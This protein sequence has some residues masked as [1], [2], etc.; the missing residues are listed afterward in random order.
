[1]TQTRT[2]GTSFKDTT[3]FAEIIIETLKEL[4]MSR[5]PLTPASLKDALAKKREF[6]QILS[7]IQHADSRAEVS[8]RSPAPQ[9][10]EDHRALREQLRAIQGQKE[11][12]LRQ[13]SELETR[14]AQIQSF[15]RRSLNLLLGLIP[16]SRNDELSDSLMCLKK[17]LVD[18]ADEEHLERCLNEL[19]DVALREAP[20]GEGIESQ[21]KDLPE[22]EKSGKESP[23]IW[24]RLLKRQDYPQ[25]PPQPDAALG[26]Q[27]VK[28]IQS[29]YLNILEEFQ[30]DVDKDYLNSLTRLK[31]RIRQCTDLEAVISLKGDI[32]AFINAF[33]R[34]MNEERAQYIEF[35][36]QVGK[37]LVELEKN[38]VDS[39][40]QSQEVHLANSQFNT[41][42]EGHMEDI[43]TSIQSDRPLAD[44][45]RMIVSRLAKIKTAL[46]TKRKEDQARNE[47]VNRKLGSLQQN[48]QSMKR[49]VNHFQ[50]KAHSLEKVAMLDGLTGIHNRRAYELRIQE[51][52]ERFK[53]YGQ[54]FSIMVFDVDHFK[55]VNDRYGH[56]AGDKCLQEMIKL[57]HP[58]LRKLDFLARYGGE[59]F[60]A[61][62]PGTAVDG[63]RNTAEKIR[64]TVER[65]CFIYQGQEIPLTISIGVTEAHPTDRDIEALFTRA[66]GALYKAKNTGRN[67]TVCITGSDR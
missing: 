45:K 31:E 12:L 6:T 46:E 62:L 25:S 11:R 28:A 56:W 13:V 3:H 38:S 61:L 30:L 51:E 24:S 44:M 41:I 27:Y 65:A 48:L 8:S 36:A 33:T 4:S 5:Q 58:V 18:G 14:Q 52:L 21:A 35:M 50:E 37:D 59:E 67:R 39:L 10:S 7:H 16:V 26:A 42:I 29:A 1:M 15:S 49:E 32:L 9:S 54:V 20:S 53:R 23:S 63:A 17:L 40:S 43:S 57:I 64:E 22:T 60:V 2:T 55:R 19:K 66:D 34:K 47:E